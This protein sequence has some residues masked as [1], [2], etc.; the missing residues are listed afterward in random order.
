MPGHNCNYHPDHGRSPAVDIPGILNTFHTNTKFSFYYI[1]DTDE[2]LNFQHFFTHG[3]LDYSKPVAMVD[4]PYQQPERC[5][6]DAISYPNTLYGFL[7]SFCVNQPDNV[8]LG[9]S[10]T[11]ARRKTNDAN[12]FSRDRWDS[13]RYS[14]NPLPGTSVL[15]NSNTTTSTITGATGFWY[16]RWTHHNNQDSSILEQILH[17]CSHRT[18][19]HLVR[20]PKNR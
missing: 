16:G 8:C 7:V 5:L 15:S 2:Y 12:W 10:P 18:H 9:D 20:D 3:L 6:L 11:I 19:Y 13:C 17:R 1:D 14:N 4:S